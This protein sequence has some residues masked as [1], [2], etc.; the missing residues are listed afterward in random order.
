M[1]AIRPPTGAPP[2]RHRSEWG[3]TPGAVGPIGLV[4]AQVSPVYEGPA[5]E[6]SPLSVVYIYDIPFPNRFA[7]SIQILRT[8]DALCR[9]GHG[10][11]LVCGRMRQSAAALASDLGMEGDLRP[12]MLS[13]FPRWPRGARLRGPV[14]RHLAA[15][16]TARRRPDLIITRGETGLALAGTAAV[17][18]P[19]R[20][21]EVHKLCFLERA[22]RRAGAPAELQAAARTAGPVHRAE[23][24]AMH[25]ADGLIFLTDG[26]RQAA[27]QAFGPL[28]APAVI[29][30][31]GVA[32]PDPGPAPAR[33]VDC[34]YAGKIERRKG[35]FLM[36]ETLAR[37]PGRT[38]RL[39]GDGSDRAAA[40]AWIERHGLGGR[41]A[42]RGPVPHARVAVELRR[43]RV[44]L[45][46]L[47]GDVDHV[48]TEFTSPLKLLEMMA[49]G[50][51][52]VATDLPSIRSLCEDGRHA[53]LAPS[54]P[55]LLAV[56]I[57][58]LLRDPDRARALG[59]AARR[60]ASEF[61]WAARAARIEALARECV[62]RRRAG[63]GHGKAPGRQR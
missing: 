60:R 14:L 29:A 39:I 11:T 21:F 30:P 53:V 15:R 41:V 9:R 37:L 24:R 4:E 20:L 62:A 5:A 45:C 27:E 58:A 57:E 25:G 47:P 51:A 31:S 8:G 63:A 56:K 22:E 23:A 50:M 48:S 33:D 44:G 28:A 3:A 38:L 7:A 17:R 43:G 32:V 6:T 54:R 35:L 1:N 26:V 19:A 34:V 55:T 40:E 16:V 18:G 13:V 36:L 59:A 61:S 42:F 52:V 12:E 10:V 2:G 46:L 49:A